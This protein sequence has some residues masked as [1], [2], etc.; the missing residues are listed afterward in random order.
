[1]HG[2]ISENKL[3]KKTKKQE[4]KTGNVSKLETLLD[5]ILY[6]V[7]LEFKFISFYFCLADKTVY[8]R[9]LTEERPLEEQVNLF[10]HLISGLLRV[11]GGLFNI[12]A[13]RSF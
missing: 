6:D 1:M 11:Y 8:N 7:R 3:S 4:G 12:R 13:K 5:L 9:Q 10:P 2:N